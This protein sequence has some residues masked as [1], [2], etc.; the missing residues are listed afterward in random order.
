MRKKSPDNSE[1]L[2]AFIA[3]QTG[4]KTIPTRLTALSAG[5]FSRTPDDIPGPMLEC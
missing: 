1:V 3:R 4:I 5:H 2:A